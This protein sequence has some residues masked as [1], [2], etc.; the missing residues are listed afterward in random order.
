MF[1]SPN[2]RNDFLTYISEQINHKQI[3]GY[4]DQTCD[5]K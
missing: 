2:I 1:T 3:E 4:N 5:G